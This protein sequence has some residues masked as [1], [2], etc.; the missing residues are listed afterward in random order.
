[1]SE[2]PTFLFVIAD[3]W[4][5]LGCTIPVAKELVRRG[6]RVVFAVSDFH[7]FINRTTDLIP[8]LDAA[9]ILRGEGLTVLDDDLPPLALPG[10]VPIVE[11]FVKDYRGFQTLFRDYL[12]PY[13]EHWASHMLPRFRELAPDA[14]WV[15]DQVLGGAMAAEVLEVPWATFSVHTGLIEDDDSLPWTMGLSPPTSIF[16][17]SR[18]VVAKWAARRFRSTLDDAFNAARHRLGLAP[19]KDALRTTAISPHLYTIFMAK[20]LDP[21][22]RAW[23]PQ[24]QFVGPYSWDEPTGYE[25]PAWTDSLRASGRPVVFATIGTLSNRIEIG[26]YSTLMDALREE[27]VEVVCSI[28][29]YG[30]DYVSKRLPAVPAN[31]HVERFVPNSVF[32][33]RADVL[34]H[35]GGAG[36]TMHGWMHGVPAVAVPLNHEHHDF[37]QRIVEQGTG[38]RLDKKKL[39][40]DALR[41]A[42]SRVLAEPSFKES[43]RRIAESIA[44]YRAVPTAAD[45]LE[46]LAR[47]GKGA[48]PVGPRT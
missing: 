28:G 35:H 32:V 36:T 27:P 30:D 31:F 16:G 12:I 34:V 13:Y 4:G 48:P 19:L 42:V 20:E 10:K 46:E 23:A 8:A 44:H 18:N 41:G 17:R 9:A 26:F 6:A 47:R 45:A 2:P 37:A 29:A 11:N 21:P 7:G 14:V 25:R 43:A 5:P 39:T 3:S 33:P 24:V 22:R 1:M 38:I 40:P 15:K